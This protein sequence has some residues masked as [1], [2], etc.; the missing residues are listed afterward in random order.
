MW[1]QSPNCLHCRS[2]Y[3]LRPWVRAHTTSAWQSYHQRPWPQ[4]T[5]VVKHGQETMFGHTTTGGN[6][7][8]AKFGWN[9]QH[10]GSGAQASVAQVPARLGVKHRAWKGH[11]FSSWCLHNPKWPVNSFQ[12]AYGEVIVKSEA[13]I[14]C[15]SAGNRNKSWGPLRHLVITHWDRRQCKGFKAMENPQELEMDAQATEQMCSSAWKQEKIE[16]V[17]LS[18]STTS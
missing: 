5:C 13:Y 3:G 11:R 17:C 1:V 18:C 9:L 14:C 6:Y 8:K 4:S 15:I 2:T 10:A 12:R 7:E 16:T